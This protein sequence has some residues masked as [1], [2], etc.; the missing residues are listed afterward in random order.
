M[1][2]CLVSYLPNLDDRLVAADRAFEN[3]PGIKAFGCSL[4][5]N[6]YGYTFQNTIYSKKNV[7]RVFRKQ[8]IIV[9]PILN[10]VALFLAYACTAIVESPPKQV[11]KI[12]CI[13]TDPSL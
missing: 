3:E 12:A 6:R 9:I 4:N 13:C 7:G 11:A 10:Y 2:L 8:E 5:G 1:R